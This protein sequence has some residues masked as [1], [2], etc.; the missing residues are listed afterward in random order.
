MHLAIRLTTDLRDRAFNA[1]DIWRAV[2]S[3]GDYHAEILGDAA[4]YANYITKEFWL[5]ETRE[6]PFIYMKERPTPTD[7][8]V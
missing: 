2:R 3:A 4:N 1:G 6:Q 8:E 7:R 5:P